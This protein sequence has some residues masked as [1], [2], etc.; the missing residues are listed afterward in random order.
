V[1]ETQPASDPYPAVHMLHGVLSSV[2]GLHP[3][4]LGRYMPVFIYLL[5]WCGLYLLAGQCF[6]KGNGRLLSM[7]FGMPLMNPSLFLEVMPMSFGISSMPFLVYVWLKAYDSGRLVIWRVCWV[8]LC[9]G[10]AFFHPLYAL[11]VVATLLASGVLQGLLSDRSSRST[12]RTGGLPTLSIKTPFGS[13]VLL[14]VVVLCLWLWQNWYTWRSA[15]VQTNAALQD[16]FWRSTLSVDFRQAQ[17]AKMTV[18]ETLLIAFR[19]YGHHLVYVIMSV[20]A[21]LTLLFWNGKHQQGSFLREVSLWFVGLLIGSV[22]GVL[23]GLGVWRLL[24]V[25]VSLSPILIASIPRLYGFSTPKKRRW[26]FALLAVVALFAHISAMLAFFTDSYTHRVS[27]HITRAE[28]AGMEWFLRNKR[29]YPTRSLTWRLRQSST[30]LFG[31]YF[32]SFNPS[33]SR[34]MHGELIVG[35]HFDL[36]ATRLPRDAQQFYIPIS[37]YDKGYHL[38]VFQASERFV[39]D[40]FEW[41]S[42]TKAASLIYSNGD[43]KVFLVD[44]CILDSDGVLSQCN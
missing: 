42:T 14:V 18:S 6:P 43:L 19:M 44:A 21:A 15:I 12:G 23:S 9:L 35:D 3:A 31:K 20:Y 28:R 39:K 38:E 34:G 11:L 7:L 17:R 1:A 32:E 29:G 40:D 36:A 10:I 24:V 41:L 25:L 30:S 2:T 4:I 8:A 27:S 22:A 26:I 13:V 33:V 16:P 5:Y 37:Q